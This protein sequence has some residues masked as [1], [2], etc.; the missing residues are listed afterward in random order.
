MTKLQ[1]FSP[2][3]AW[4]L[5]RGL[6]E[7]FFP[8]PNLYKD[9]EAARFPFPLGWLPA[10]STVCPLHP[11]PCAGP[12]GA[13]QTLSPLGTGTVS[14]LLP[15]LSPSQGKRACWAETA[16]QQSFGGKK[17]AGYITA[18]MKK[19]PPGTIPAILRF[20]IQASSLSK[21]S[22]FFSQQ[23]L[24]APPKGSPALHCGAKSHLLW[25]GLGTGCPKCCLRETGEEMKVESKTSDKQFLA[26][27]PTYI[28][29]S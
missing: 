19:D 27:R 29:P 22:G 23:S 3:L 18:N 6:A 25:A 26:P 21:H 14:L 8:C 15:N 7:H 4:L 11:T 5:R 28:Y 1:L 12:P 2:V 10:C 9:S 20:N 16:T 17:E 13:T 24:P